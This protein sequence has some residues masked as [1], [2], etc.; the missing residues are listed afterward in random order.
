MEK[1]FFDTLPGLILLLAYLVTLASTLIFLGPGEADDLKP[2]FRFKKWVLKRA[3][4]K[5]RNY[6]LVLAMIVYFVISP[7]LFSYSFLVW[8]FK[9]VYNHD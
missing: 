8:C 4:A 3:S 2:Y 5:T 9:P 6:H 7:I 1:G